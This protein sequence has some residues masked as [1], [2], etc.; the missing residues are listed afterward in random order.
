MVYRYMYVNECYMMEM[1]TT[2]YPDI[3]YPVVIPS[4]QRLHPENGQTIDF[5]SSST[6]Y[7]RQPKNSKH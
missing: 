6:L 5:M 4:P 2:A 3:D 7:D 1:M